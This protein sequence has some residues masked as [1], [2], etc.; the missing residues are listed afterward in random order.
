MARPPR[1]LIVDE[2]SLGLAPIVVEEV[3]ETLH[4]IKAAGTALLIIEQ[5]VHHALEIA[6]DAAI[7]H[8]GRIAFHGPAQGLS[9]RADLLSGGLDG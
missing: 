1:L 5:H 8:Q 9:D 2:L 6:D 7:L 4:R 3:Y